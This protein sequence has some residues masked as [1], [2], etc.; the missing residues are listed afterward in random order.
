MS[1]KKTIDRTVLS[2]LVIGS[3]VLIN[4]VGVTVFKRLDLTHDGRFTLSSA[5]K[6]TLANLKDP[7][8]VT[9]Y[10]TEDLPPR[11]AS[12]ER[13]LRDLLDEYY[14]AGHGNFRFEFI[15]PVSQETEEDKEKKKDIKRDMW[16]REVREPTS[17]ERELARLGV[18]QVN[19]MVSDGNRREERLAYLGLV[20]HYGDAHEVIS[21]VQQTAGLEY[22]LTTLIRKLTRES[23][24]KI[25]LIGGGSHGGPSARNRL[26]R[27]SGVL[28]QM[29]ELI[30]PDLAS[31]TDGTALADADALLVIGPKTPLNEQE[32]KL[33]D[34]F[35]MSGRPA[36][37]LLGA[38][39]PDIRTLDPGV[40][41]HG[42]GPM[43]STWGVSIGAGLVLD[44]ECAELQISQ[45]RGFLTIRQ[46]K[47]YPFVPMPRVLDADNPVTRGL[48]RVSFPF[49]SPL[50]VTAPDGVTARIVVA[51]SPRSWIQLPPYDLNPLQQWTADKVKEEGA[52]NLIITLEGPLRSHFVTDP[53]EDGVSAP[54]PD[55]IAQAEHARVFV[56]GGFAF[57]LDDFMAP[58]NQR[59]VL[60]LIDW[61]VQD[62]A[63]LA[64][65][66]RGFDNAPLDE[67]S[68]LK[69][70]T[71][72]FLNILGLPVLFVGFG[73]VRWRLREAR[74]SKIEV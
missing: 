25:A 15:D 52:K 10:F 29:Y 51:S 43:L 40:A 54:P 7:V 16:G 63:L 13:N 49:M 44:A 36:A 42:L 12:I 35:V 28:G 3:L 14:A 69:R 11:F 48:S 67:I 41:D 26:V 66:S 21:V 64:V 18:Q 50:T 56:A 33:I 71:L 38:V 72:K 37:F 22:N 74:R 65:R 57:V 61:M 27:M 32:Q 1:A 45:Q 46:P 31:D 39:D 68:D 60:N 70:N 73:V 5:T 23:P 30:T 53:S 58:G 62:E 20:I 2:L 55:G 9:A 17:I 4:V 59:L 24:P 19:V 34:Q 47:K 6:D 8:T